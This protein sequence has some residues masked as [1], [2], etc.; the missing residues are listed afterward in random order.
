MHPYPVI[1]LSLDH[2]C[3]Q[4][5]NL[6]HLPQAHVLRALLG[7]SSTPLLSVIDPCYVHVPTLSL[8]SLHL[9]LSNQV[10]VLNDQLSKFTVHE[11]LRSG[12]YT[13]EGVRNDRD[14]QIQHHDN[15]E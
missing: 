2:E 1:L 6:S 8:L 4:L 12:G 3:D 9:L 13:R 11:L 15:Q 5:L 7:T 10:P 14:Q